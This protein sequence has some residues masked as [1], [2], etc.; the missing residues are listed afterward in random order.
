MKI[1]FYIG[2]H[3]VGSTALQ[4]YLSQNW[5]ALAQAGILYPSVEAEGVA[6]NLSRLLSGADHP[7]VPAIN[8]REPHNALAFRMMGKVTKKPMP[9]YHQNLPALQQMLRTLRAQIDQMQPK[10][11]VLCS[12]VMANFG[13]LEPKLIATLKDALPE[14]DEVELYCALRRPDH[15]LASWHGQRL[16]FGHKVAPLRDGG[17][18][19]YIKGIHFNYRRLLQPWL[20]HFPDAQVH[21]RNYAD[22]L[23]SGGSVEDFIA[24]IPAPFP[25]PQGAG[26]RRNPSLPHATYEIMRRGNHALERA[27]ML[28]LRHYLMSASAKAD[29]P[30]NNEVELFGQKTRDRLWDAFAPVGDYL[31]QFSGG[32]TF[33]PD[34]EEMRQPNA[35]A[36]I[37]L[38]P[39]VLK[40]LARVRPPLL[41]KRPLRRFLK[42]VKKDLQSA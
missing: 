30:R 7:K 11:V 12:E 34:L 22:I 18:E 6:D 3:K 14:A 29:L 37:A 8:V 41:E 40:R 10:V 35:T 16:K 38:A 21:V 42:S 33:F 15:Y 17:A 19:A 20:R 25:A 31:T 39:E 24:H 5:L 28:Q 32:A 36:D 27:D 26:E 4:A 23:K 1:I 2:H 9:R 13:A